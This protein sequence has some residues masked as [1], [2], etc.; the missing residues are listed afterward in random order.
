MRISLMHRAW[1]ATSGTLVVAVAALLSTGCNL[2][3][4]LVAPQNPG[5]IDEGAASGPTSANGLRIGALG[6]LKLQTGSGETLWHFPMPQHLEGRDKK[7]IVAH[8]NQLHA[9]AAVGRP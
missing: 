7:T 2:R 3:H 9:N 4:E 1:A 8:W 5:V 6:A